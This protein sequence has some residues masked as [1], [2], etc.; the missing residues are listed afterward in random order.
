M[1][2]TAI[3][4]TDSSSNNNNVINTIPMPRSANS[5]TIVNG[6]NHTIA[7]F[8][9]RGTF[10]NKQLLQPGEAVSM[11]REQTGG[12][13]LLPYKVHAVIAT[14]NDRALPTK[15]DSIKNLLI[16]S[17]TPAAF[18]AGVVTTVYSAGTYSAAIKAGTVM[19]GRTQTIKGVLK[20]LQRTNGDD[21]TAH[22]TTV[23]SRSFLPGQRYLMVSGGLSD[24]TPITIEEIPKRNLN[25]IRIKAMKAPLVASTKTESN[26]NN[27]RQC[28][29][30][31]EDQ[32][33][34]YVPA[35]V[36]QVM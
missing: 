20:K 25:K 7:V 1:T 13:L 35:H 6:T 29:S 19:V 23:V 32:G 24:G 8:L 21:E 33:A 4:N 3:L 14:D 28:S 17:A 22:M 27:T 11:T 10:Y 34:Y 2:S 30:I 18:V 36:V 26:K 31:T 15:A 5:P 12:G 16:V 9:E